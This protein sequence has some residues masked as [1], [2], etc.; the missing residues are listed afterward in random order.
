MGLIAVGGLNQGAVDGRGM[1]E[2]DFVAAER[3]GLKVNIDRL[4]CLHF[5]AVTIPEDTALWVQEC[6][7]S[8]KE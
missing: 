2:A 8:V 4:K 6:V 5:P 3:A 7:E 1:W